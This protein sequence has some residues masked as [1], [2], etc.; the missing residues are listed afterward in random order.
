MA[1]CRPEF[2]VAFRA[3]SLLKDTFEGAEEKKR[4]SQRTTEA[5]LSE[6]CVQ[7]Q[8][9]TLTLHSVLGETHFDKLVGVRS[10]VFFLYVDGGRRGWM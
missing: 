4:S 9:S 1:G 6:C 8:A 7:A 2:L 10:H 3:L 5:F